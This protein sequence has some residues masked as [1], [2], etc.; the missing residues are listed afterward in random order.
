[1]TEH[2]G[3]PPQFAH[4]RRHLLRSPRGDEEVLEWT[5]PFR[6]TYPD[7]LAV[8]GWH[9]VGPCVPIDPADDALV[10]QVAKALSDV[11]GYTPTGWLGFI[12]HA[13]A[14][15]AAILEKKDG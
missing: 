9:Y 13:R 14:A 4:L 12:P 7:W 15:I 5:P 8:I 3:P 11:C 1:M 6:H 10:E 2:I